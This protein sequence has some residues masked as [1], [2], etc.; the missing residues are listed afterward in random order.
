LKRNEGSRSN[1]ERRGVSSSLLASGPPGRQERS[2]SP[3]WRKDFPHDLP[4]SGSA[5]R[6]ATRFLEMRKL[7]KNQG[8]A[9]ISIVTGRYRLYDAAL[10]DLGFPASI[11]GTDGETAAVSFATIWRHVQC[12]IQKLS[13]AGT[14]SGV[15]PFNPRPVIIW[16]RIV[17]MPRLKSIQALTTSTKRV[18]GSR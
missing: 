12:A 5:K 13:S 8:R 9:P 3:E 2:G 11:V 4:A 18:S 16:S 1:W 6:L 10:R 14:C 17:P 7:L 15:T